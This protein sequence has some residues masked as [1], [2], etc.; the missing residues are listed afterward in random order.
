P[1]GDTQP[2][3]GPP[4]PWLRWALI[5]LVMIGA[6][7][8]GAAIHW[9]TSTSDSA[10]P[11]QQASVQDDLFPDPAR[12]QEEYALRKLKDRENKSDLEVTNALLDLTM[13]YIREKK[14]DEAMK[15]YRVEFL[16][17]RFALAEAQKTFPGGQYFN[18]LIDLGKGIILAHQDLAAESNDEFKKV[19][20]P[21]LIAKPKIR[22]VPVFVASPL[23]VVTLNVTTIP[24]IGKDKP[25]RMPVDT[26][27]WKYDRWKRIVA[28][29]LERNAKN[30]GTTRLDDD[31]LDRHRSYSSK[32]P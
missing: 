7:G 20:I 21:S 26:F 9:Q 29:S 31:H 18:L 10:K 13:I 22:F 25:A 19:M 1:N 3:M 8:V 23:R 12:A 32:M 15:L 16:R 14:F 4:T 27:L 11:K 2:L 28:D 30:L 24:K 6:G 5:S 17:D